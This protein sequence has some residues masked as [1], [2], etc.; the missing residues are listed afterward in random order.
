M[1]HLTDSVRPPPRP[2]SG[3]A[4]VRAVVHPLKSSVLAWVGAIFLS[5]G[6]LILAIML[7][8]E[9]R[10]RPLLAGGSPATATVVGRHSA[11]HRDSDGDSVRRYYIQYEFP[12]PDGRT[13]AAEATVARGKWNEVAAGDQLEVRYDP[14]NPERSVLLQFRDSTL[15]FFGVPFS[16][17]FVLL[18]GLLLRAGLRGVLTP[19]RLYRTG[20][21]VGGRVTGL[22]TVTSET[23]NGQHPVRVHYAFLDGRGTERQGS[24]KTMDGELLDA[25]EEGTEVVVLHDPGAPARSA[26]LAALG[27]PGSREARRFHLQEEKS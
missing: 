26:L 6:L 22:E 10:G 9:L 27:V 12:L 23:L 20:D 7:P 25:L 15:L 11:T 17:L 5:A 4:A 1:L 16:G 24:L 13:W 18:G 14:G 8:V 2:L 21:A 19:L 3:M